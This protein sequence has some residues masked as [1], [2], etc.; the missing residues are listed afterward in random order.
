MTRQ[1]TPVQKD[2]ARRFYREVERQLHPDHPRALPDWER[3]VLSMLTVAA[4]PVLP[5]HWKE[6]GTFALPPQ[7]GLWNAPRGARIPELEEALRNPPS[8]IDPEEVRSL[9]EAQAAE[10][11]KPYRTGRPTRPPSPCKVG[12]CSV[13]ARG[14]EF[15]P[16]C[17]NRLLIKE[18]AR[19]DA[20]SSK[21]AAVIGE[22]AAVIK[23]V[24][25]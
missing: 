4:M 17:A 7:H 24:Q 22:L 10:Q 2:A 12:G 15:C 16:N 9:A 18:R 23:R 25:G 8:D 3:N 21:L 19:A 5:A 1:M 13:P 6:E 14:G 20:L 11:A